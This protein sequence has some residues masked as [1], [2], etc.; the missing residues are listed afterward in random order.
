M[1]D[2]KTKD[3]SPQQKREEMKKEAWIKNVLKIYPN[4]TRDQAE[5]LW[6]KLFEKP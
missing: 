2:N 1:T 5:E 3:I 6:I 4:K